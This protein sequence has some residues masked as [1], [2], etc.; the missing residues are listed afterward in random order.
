LLP[1]EQHPAEV[2]ALDSAPIS[3]ASL[4]ESTMSDGG[5]VAAG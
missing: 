5:Q 4:G 1:A 2:S 3:G